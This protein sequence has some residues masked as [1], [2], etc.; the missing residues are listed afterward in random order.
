MNVRNRAEKWPDSLIR[1]LIEAL[2]SQ[3]VQQGM[4]SPF[5]LE[6]VKLVT[7][8]FKAKIRPSSLLSNWSFDNG[9]TTTGPFWGGTPHSRVSNFLFLTKALQKMAP[10]SCDPGN[11]YV[12]K[13]I[14]FRWSLSRW[15]RDNGEGDHFLQKIQRARALA[16]QETNISWNESGTTRPGMQLSPS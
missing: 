5:G 2:F 8:I 16:W 11:S 9:S 10:S 7:N 12:F 4:V 13:N 14:P 15:K 1:I 6:R 3:L